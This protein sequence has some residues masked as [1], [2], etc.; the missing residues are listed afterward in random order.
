MII[1]CKIFQN[2]SALG[3]G[4]KDVGIVVALFEGV[5]ALGLA[6][7]ARLELNGVR[8]QLARGRARLQG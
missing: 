7:R 2:G 6:L 3:N 5:V 8:P 4:D 1:S